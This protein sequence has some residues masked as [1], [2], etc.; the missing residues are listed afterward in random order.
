MIGTFGFG[1][2]AQ[3][4]IVSRLESGPLA[5]N[6]GKSQGKCKNIASGKNRFRSIFGP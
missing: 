2:L 5:E 3:N 6:V 1:P 4:G